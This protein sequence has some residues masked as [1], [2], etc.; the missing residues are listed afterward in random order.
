[1]MPDDLS[2]AELFLSLER[3]LHRPEVRSSSQRVADLL[4]D[5]FLEFGSSGKVYNK[6]F[7]LAALAKETPPAGSL[8]PQVLDFKITPLSEA[9]VLV[10]YKSKR[11]PSATEGGRHTLRSSI[12]KLLDG[13]WQMVFHQGTIIPQVDT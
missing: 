5:D 7:T 1:M 9:V 10:T 3:S 11:L 4:A 2:N 6:Q 13:R 12:W 8:L